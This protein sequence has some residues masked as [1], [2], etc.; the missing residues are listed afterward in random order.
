MLHSFSFSSLH[1]LHALR[2]CPPGMHYLH[3]AR[4]PRFWLESWRPLSAEAAVVEQSEV[5]RD[6][7]EGQGLTKK[8]APVAAAV[9]ELLLRKERVVALKAAM[10]AAAEAAAAGAAA[11]EPASAVAQA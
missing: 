6:L 11:A 8:D 1:A 10:E 9:E 7:K 2:M 3:L 4:L 5:V